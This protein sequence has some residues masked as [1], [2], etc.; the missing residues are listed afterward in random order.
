MGE[1]QSEHTI[2]TRRVKQTEN[3]YDQAKKQWESERAM[4]IERCASA[5]SSSAGSPSPNKSRRSTAQS[6]PGLGVPY[7]DGSS[8]GGGGD[9]QQGDRDSLVIEQLEDQVRNLG[10]Q[11]LKKQ[12]AMQELLSERAGLKVRLQDA[13]RR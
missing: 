13:Q 3:D 12:E 4:L 5:S 9:M 1:L 7:G 8:G 2:M 11:L 10:Q 6:N